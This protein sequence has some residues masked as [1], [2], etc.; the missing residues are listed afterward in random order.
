MVNYYCYLGCG[1]LARE[2]YQ[3]VSKTESKLDL[4]MLPSG[5]H[6]QPTRLHQILQDEID[7]IEAIN[8]SLERSPHT[9]E[10]YQAVLLGFGLCNK[11]VAGL[12]STR[13]PLVIPRAHDCLTLLLGSKEKYRE[14]FDQDPASY[15][16][17]S[18][19]IE[20]MLPPGPERDRMLVEKYSKAYGSENLQFLMEQAQKWEKQYQSASLITFGST[21]DQYYREL[22]QNCAGRLGW[23]LREYSGSLDLLH[24]LFSGNWLPQRFLVVQPGHEIIPSFDDQIITSKAT[25]VNI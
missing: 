2:V 15:W 20:R 25:G 4:R 5:L 18:G 19:W 3:A 11:A 22:T 7:R 8:V 23:A 14:L 9:P 10:V 12:R 6:E 16:F 1:V 17:S 24:E 13:V 21:H